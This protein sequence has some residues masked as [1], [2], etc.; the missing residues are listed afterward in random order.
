MKKYNSFIFK[1]YDFDRNKRELTLAYSYDNELELVERYKFDF[2]YTDYDERALDKAMNLLFFVAGVSYY[3]S[4]LAPAI[5]IDYG[6]VTE[7]LSGFLSRT[8]Q[9][10][11]GEFFYLNKLDPKTEINFPINTK[12][13]EKTEVINN[14][15]K[16]IGIGGGKDSLVSVEMLRDEPDVNTFSVNHKAL[17]EPLVEKIGLP[18]LWV[19]RELDP[20]I[21]EI[22]A[23]GAY[24]GHVP[25][26]AIIACV[27]LVTSILGGLKDVV[28]SN[29]SSASEP[30]LVYEGVPINH[31]YSKSLDFE[32]DFQQ[33]LNIFYGDSIRY[34][35]LLRPLSEL[36][37]AELFAATAFTKYRSV[38]NSCNRAYTGHGNHLFWCG[39]C[40]K[41]A[42]TYLLLAP[43]IKSDALDPL[44]GKNLLLEP[45]LKDTYEKLLGIAGEQRPLDCVGDVKESRTAMR[46][47]QKLYP[48]L[49]SYNFFVPDNYDYR[50]LS[51]HSMPVEM[52]EILERFIM[53]SLPE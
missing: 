35:S 7:E 13:I 17:L 44:W 40:P 42:F 3:K 20:K 10:G 45:S 25:I 8:Y 24:N 5:K 37:I 36:R 28:V 14:G 49:N 47:A 39:E 43:F 23:S 18:H 52:Y 21:K 30:N 38:F 26:S 4:F 15:G 34:Y 2:D 16:L 11:L 33:L 19:E 48:V 6:V 29:E 50:S 51:P 12:N 9:K 31:Q 53:R 27:G 1:H 22:N 41:C 32:T 46:M